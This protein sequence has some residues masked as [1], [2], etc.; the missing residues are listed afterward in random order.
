MEVVRQHL[1]AQV[2]GHPDEADLIAR[3]R[4]GDDTQFRSSV[5]ELSLYATLRGL[6]YQVK[7]HPELTNGLSFRPDFFVTPPSGESFYLEAV[8][9]GENTGDPSG[10]PLIATTLDAFT[11]ASHSNF[12]VMVKQRGAPTTQPSRKRL[13]RET[14]RWL[15]T[16]DPDEVGASINSAGWAYAPQFEWVHEDLKLILTAMP[17]SAER[18]GKASRL[19]GAQ[20]GQASWVNTSSPLRAAIEFKGRKYGQLE[21]PLVIAVNVANRHMDRDDEM[22]ALFGDEQVVVSVSD[23]DADGRVVRKPNGA[24]L[25][26][27]GPRLTRVSAAWI[28]NNLSLY[29]LATVRGTLYLNPWPQ[30]A[31]P[32][33]LRTFAHAEDDDQDGEMRWHI[34]QTLGE[35]LGLS[36]RWPEQP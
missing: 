27:T 17:L 14:L 18:R 32:H 25:G 5:F 22:Q 16:L 2:S 8:L 6:G 10:N 23:A 35:A 15:D 24:W 11:R 1:E 13:L 36:A 12:T 9:A 20:F 28:F 19:L 4:S 33:D 21:A 7:C 31:A 34:G 29:N 30:H 26:P 3:L